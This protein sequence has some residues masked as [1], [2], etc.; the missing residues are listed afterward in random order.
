MSLFKKLL[1][2]QI[3]FLDGA[4]G[5]MV[6]TH[7]LTEEDFRGELFKTHPKSLKGNN[8]L[9]NLTQPELVKK[10]HLDYLKAGANI[11]ETNTFNST[12]LSQKDYG[13][14]KIVYDLNKKAAQLA[15]EAISEYKKSL[16]AHQE[17]PHCF[18]AGAV[19]PTS[20]TLSISPKVEDPSFRE[21]DFDQVAAAYFE[22]ISGLVDGGVDL[23]LI[24]TVFDTL[25]LKACLWALSQIELERKL[26]LDIILSVTITDSS[27][28]TLSGQTIEAFWNSIRHAKP[29]AVGIN[30]ALGAEDMKPYIADLSRIADCY[31]SC[32]PNAGLPNPLSA[33]GYDETPEMLAKTLSEYVQHGYLNIIGGCCGT[34]PAHIKAIVDSVKNHPPRK[35]PQI[36]KGATRLSGLESLNISPD[37]DHPFIIVG[38]RTNITG[39]PAF[40][41]AIKENNFEKGLLIA[42]QQV[43]NGANILDINFDEGLIDG[44]KS[45]VKFLNL[46]ASEPEISKIPIMID[47]SNWQILKSGLKC[48]QGK[49]VVNSL[50]LKDGEKDFLEKAQ[51]VQQMGAAIVVMAFDEHGQAATTEE[52]VRIC[53]RAYDLLM[54]IQFPPEDII[55]DPNVLT[56]ATGIEEHK[57]FGLNFIEAL[58]EI[59]KVCPWARTSGGISNLSFSFR[60]NNTI[61]EAMHSVF[62]FHS[63]KAGLD[64]GII[65]AGMLQIYDEIDPHL[66]KLV[67][68]V[69][70]CT[71]PEAEE[72]LL[73]LASEIQNKSDSSPSLAAKKTKLEWREWDLQKRINHSLVH[74]VDEF[75]EQDMTEALTQ[76]SKPLEI[77]E[78]PLMEGM[79]IVGELFGAGKM[80][81]PQV[82]KSARVMK[83]AVFRAF[84]A[85]V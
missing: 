1:E 4:F 24:E 49:G 79:K 37:K 25:N 78:G 17:S 11:I 23:L 8:D 84:S 76:F 41:K 6:Q 62:L 45:M 54:S 83:K 5:T 60:G 33:T 61:R 2:S 56:V 18:V 15:Q 71:S 10:I 65:N 19:G 30:C 44:E 21:V 27:G 53:K 43:E 58:S 9:L 82:V 46:I 80:F 57:R 31:I 26:K 52:K 16:S 63:L 12:S 69:I 73:E 68:D 72:H 32:Y 81:L 7:R 75:V 13:L 64:L 70:L 14:E 55:F 22:Q 50:S 39:S 51:F 3:L 47:S 66:K 42:R 74:G 35:I 28:R 34:T 40:A 48:L 38:E 36:Q 20:K 29:L 77:I 85:K 67:E 59:K